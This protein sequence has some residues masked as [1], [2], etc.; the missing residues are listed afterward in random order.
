ML[1]QQQQGALF[2][3]AQTQT[4]CSWLHSR[5]ASVRHI[6]LNGTSKLI[7][8]LPCPKLQRLILDNNSVDLRPGSQLLQDL[9]SATALTR[10][11]FGNVTYQGEPD[12]AA[13]LLALPNLQELMLFI[14]GE[15]AYIKVQDSPQHQ[16]Q[17]LHASTASEV[18]DSHQPSQKLWSAHGDPADGYRCFT[19]SGMQL[20]C[21]LAKLV[22]LELSSLQ[23]V[24]AAGLS[25][26]I[27]LRGLKG[28]DLFDLTCDISLSA[29]P[30]FSQL[31]ALTDLALYWE[32][33]T[34]DC[35]FDPAILAHMTQLKGLQLIQCTP[36]CGAAGA[37]ELLSRLSQ[38]PDLRKLDF[39]CVKGLEQCPPVAFSSLTSSSMLES[40]TWET[41]SPFW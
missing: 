21:K 40:L 2:W 22:G 19:D 41:R 23:G 13:V 33:D 18:Q 25:G 32:R 20:V 10:L 35:E 27:N 30:A 4:A 11:C 36:A 3:T 12:L 14:L 26:L 8:T 39:K 29:V 1:Q 7:N 28:L 34:P 37:A 5:G 6:V 24:T 31:T 17:Q 38:L 16:R 15:E 9:C